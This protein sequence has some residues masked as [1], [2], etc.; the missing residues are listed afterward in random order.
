M[1]ISVRNR[2]RMREAAFARIMESAMDCYMTVSRG[3]ASPIRQKPAASC[4]PRAKN[5]CVISLSLSLTLCRVVYNTARKKTRARAYFTHTS[6]QRDK[7]T[8]Q[9]AS[10]IKGSRVTYMLMMRTRHMCIGFSF[11]FFFCRRRSDT[12]LAIPTVHLDYD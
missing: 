8:D 6:S 7:S 4:S 3:P 5:Y 12:F 10:I 2:K 11:S 1:Y 9:N